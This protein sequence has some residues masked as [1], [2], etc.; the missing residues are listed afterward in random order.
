MRKVRLLIFNR[1]NEMTHYLTSCGTLLLFD[2]NLCTSAGLKEQVY[3]EV[4]F[5]FYLDRN[6]LIGQLIMSCLTFIWKW[7]SLPSPGP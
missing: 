3:C 4:P 6:S 2:I 1:W 7:E 5:A